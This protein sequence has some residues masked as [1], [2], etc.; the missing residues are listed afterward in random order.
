MVGFWQRAHGD[1]TGR[2]AVHQR[3]H[4]CTPR[5][6]VLTRQ[7]REFGVEILKAEVDAQGARVLAKKLAHGDQVLCAVGIQQFDLRSTVHGF[8]GA[9]PTQAVPAAQIITSAKASRR[10][11]RPSALAGVVL[12]K[13]LSPNSM[14][15]IR[16][17]R[18]LKR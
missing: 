12:G 15:R 5:W 6:R 16:F 11:G 17:W 14:G 13:C 8:H 3:Q 1:T 2:R 4:E 9:R 18:F 7:A 10:S